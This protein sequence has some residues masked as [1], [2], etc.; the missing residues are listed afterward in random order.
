MQIDAKYSDS[1]GAFTGTTQWTLA[2]ARIVLVVGL[3]LFTG[4]FQWARAQ[5]RAPTRE[6][7]IKAAF[8]YHFARFVDWPSDKSTGDLVICVL[9]ENPFGSALENLE[10]KSVGTRKLTTVQL[11]ENTGIADCHILFV[12]AAAEHSTA[13][14]L[15]EI[16]SEGVL[17]VG[18]TDTF[19]DDGG[20][21]RLF[22]A[23]NNIRFEINRE[24]ARRAGLTISSRMLRLASSG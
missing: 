9:G 20:M 10:G 5:D 24:A 6:Y 1:A 4:T 11:T 22:A 21:I 13:E 15:A 16:P 23:E 19:D 14:L 12:S 8:L 7:E 18:E 2:Q 3:C 17:T